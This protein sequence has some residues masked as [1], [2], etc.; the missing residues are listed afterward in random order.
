MRFE[1]GFIPPDLSEP[2][3]TE[4]AYPEFDGSDLAAISEFNAWIDVMTMAYLPRLAARARQAAEHRAVS[5]RDFNVGAAVYAIDP[6]NRRYGFLYGAN[7]TPYQGSPKRCAEMEATEKAE[8][9]RY[10]KIQ[11]IAVSGPIQSHASGLISETLHPC[12]ACQVMFRKHPLIYPDTLVLTADE[13]GSAHELYDMREFF[14]IHGL[15]F[16][17]DRADRY[18]DDLRL[19]EAIKSGWG[20]AT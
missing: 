15:D 3:D 6:V 8:E 5:Y 16:F 9:H 20:D 14:R 2:E 1:K 12:D 17:D 11:A 10:K 4:H 18:T 19:A 13:T 7:L